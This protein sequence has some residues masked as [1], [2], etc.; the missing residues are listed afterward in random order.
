MLERSQ[1]EPGDTEGIAVGATERNTSQRTRYSSG[2]ARSCWYRHRCCATNGEAMALKMCSISWLVLNLVRLGLLAAWLGLTGMKVSHFLSEPTAL[3][4]HVDENPDMPYITVIGPPN[5]QIVTTN[6]TTLLEYARARDLNI[7]ELSGNMYRLYRMLE[8]GF[9]IKNA[10]NITTY[11]DGDGMWNI[12][13]TSRLGIGATLT[14]NRKRNMVLLRHFYVYDSDDLFRHIYPP[15]LRYFVYFHGEPHFFGFDDRFHSSVSIKNTTEP[16]SIKLKVQRQVKLNLRREPCE[17]DPTYEIGECRRKCFLSWLKCRLHGT[18]TDDG[19]PVCM[20]DDLLLYA[21]SVKFFFRGDSYKRRNRESVVPADRCPCPQPCVRDH[22]SVSDT[23][24]VGHFSIPGLVKI[25]VSRLRQTTVMVLT[26]G[27]E[28]LLADMGG[29]LG[30]LLGAS[31]LSVFGAGRRLVSRLVRRVKRRRHTADKEEEQNDTETDWSNY[32]GDV[33][34]DGNGHVS[35][36]LVNTDFLT[37]LI[38]QEF[39]KLQVET[40]GQ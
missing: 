4:S 40:S 36:K 8:R 3:R 28:D 19:K 27:L 6:Q 10:K 11:E 23:S 21:R 5:R 1:Q 26:Y 30:L 34:S 38:Q 33:A 22:I 2:A 35:V 24:S 18:Q 12:I 13:L 14:P 15:E 32:V 17:E 7:Y 9:D 39:Q 31:L 37:R 16:Q 29:Y 25:S 20:E